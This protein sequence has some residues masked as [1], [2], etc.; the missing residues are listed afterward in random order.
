MTSYRVANPASF[1][2]GP[3]A[4]GWRNRPLNAKSPAATVGLLAT[5]SGSLDS[6][7]RTSAPRGL[8]SFCFSLHR[9]LEHSMKGGP[10][11]G[12]RGSARS[13][14]IFFKLLAF[15]PT[16]RRPSFA[17]SRN[18]VQC[19]VQPSANS[20]AVLGGQLGG[21]ERGRRER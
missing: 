5:C 1:Q 8:I 13:K 6:P 11:A 4:V 21:V 12:R 18:E 9:F 19:K 14:R 7:T 15:E 10:A 3:D 17:S 16:P 2:L 20:D